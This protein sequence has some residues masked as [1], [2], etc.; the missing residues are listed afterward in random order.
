MGE[1]DWP[2]HDPKKVA[3]TSATVGNIHDLRDH[4][5]ARAGASGVTHPVAGVDAVATSPVICY[6]HKIHGASLD[7]SNRRHRPSEC[8]DAVKMPIVTIRGPGANRHV[9]CRTHEPRVANGPPRLDLADERLFQNLSRVARMRYNLADIHKTLRIS[10]A[11]AAGIE[12]KLWPVADI[13]AMTD[14]ALKS[15]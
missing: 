2:K 9:I 7:S 6:V 5:I 14:T 1:R 12:D 15:N 13:V 10:P 3:W 11:M 8:T 4:I